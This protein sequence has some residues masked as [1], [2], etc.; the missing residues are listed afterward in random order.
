MLKCENLPSTNS[1]KFE[2][3]NILVKFQQ[4]KHTPVM[5]KVSI[6][7]SGYT[8]RGHIYRE[9]LVLLKFWQFSSE[10]KKTWNSGAT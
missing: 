2:T 5:T 10:L 7:L 4:N 8:M 1:T 6:E 3:Q 9:V